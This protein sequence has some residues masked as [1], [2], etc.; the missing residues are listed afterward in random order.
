MTT[1]KP[2][3]TVTL[4]WD[5]YK[6]LEQVATVQGCSMSSVLS[7]VWGE[8]APF[9]LKVAKLILEAKAAKEAVGD[10]IRE[11]A[12]DAE[13]SMVPLARELV[14]NMDMFEASIKEAVKGRYSEGA[15]A[16]DGGVRL[17][18]APSDASASRRRLRGARS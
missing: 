1:K 10:R 2:R 13:L 7:E 5:D 12:A 6:A 18:S 16:A 9:M 8:A 3:I 4:D 11:I 15:G 17:S 14:S